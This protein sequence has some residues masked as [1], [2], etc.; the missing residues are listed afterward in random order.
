VELCGFKKTAIWLWWAIDR[1]TRRVLGW[2]L[3]DRDTRAAQALGAQIPS[4]PHIQYTSD[5]YRCYNAIFP[6]EQHIQS[7]AQTHI[8]ESMNNKL[9][10]Y[11]A[12]L[13]R[14]SHCY[15]K[16]ADNLRDSLLFIFQRK[17]NARLAPSSAFVV[18]SRLWDEDISIPV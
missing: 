5:H 3:G 11:L 15:S 12:R 9:R 8:I 4:S 17:F 18:C 13:R 16:S 7:K 6:K 2:V 1:T 10:C 14:K